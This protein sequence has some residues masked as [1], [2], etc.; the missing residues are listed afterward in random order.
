MTFDQTASGGEA[1]YIDG[2]LDDTNANGSAWSWTTGQPLEIGYS[3]DTTWTPYNGLLSD[4]RYY[5]TNLTAS[6]IS[7][8]YSSGAPVDTADLQMDLAFGAAPGNGFVL[9][10]AEGSA[11]LQSAPTLT[12]PWTDVTGAASPYTIVPAA[13]QQFF[14][15]RHTPQNL[16][17]NPY[18]M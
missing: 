7:T 18:L 5:S 10:W 13:S 9:K 4:V 11:V 8:I 17:S 15:Y 16:V 3:S 6:Q 2:A 14:R 1:L 12:G